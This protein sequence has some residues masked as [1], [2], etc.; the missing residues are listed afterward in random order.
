MKSLPTPYGDCNDNSNA[1]VSECRLACVTRTVVEMCGC[2]DVYMKPINKATCKLFKLIK[3][4]G[5]LFDSY[6]YSSESTLNHCEVPAVSNGC[7][8]WHALGTA[9]TVTRVPRY[10]SVTVI[11]SMGL[12][13]VPI[14]SK[15]YLQF[16][17][18]LMCCTIYAGCSLAA[19]MS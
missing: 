14:T 5:N 15:S 6:D 10:T 19:T 4:T 11:V 18:L 8:A 9:K 16:T 12:T 1:S 7:S 13:S 17:S 2:H 3:T